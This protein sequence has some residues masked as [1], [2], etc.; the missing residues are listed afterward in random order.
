[1]QL[2][3]S[4]GTHASLPPTSNIP[5]ESMPQTVVLIRSCRALAFAAL[6]GY[7]SYRNGRCGTNRRALVRFSDC[8]RNYPLWQSSMRRAGVVRVV[9]IQLPTERFTMRLSWWC[10]RWLTRVLLESRGGG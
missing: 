9:A 4:P 7:C 1:M 6:V 10:N 5:R 2:Q 8:F 3:E